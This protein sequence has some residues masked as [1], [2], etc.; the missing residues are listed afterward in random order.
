MDVELLL[1]YTEGALASRVHAE[2]E[3]LAEEHTAE[4]TRL[5]ARVGAELAAAVLP[6]ARA[7]TAPGVDVP[8][9][10]PRLP[11]SASRTGRGSTAS[12][13]NP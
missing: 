2:G 7:G 8:P 1:P 4:G 10:G 13:V 12:R 6:F 5:H 9:T 11:A 3:V